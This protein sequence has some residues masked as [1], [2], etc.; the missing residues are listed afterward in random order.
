VRL[1]RGERAVA[2]DQPSPLVIESIGMGGE[3]VVNLGVDRRL[4][5]PSGSFANQ[6]IEW[7]AGVEVRAKREHLRVHRRVDWCRVGGCRS[8][9]HGVSPCPRRAVEE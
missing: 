1:P 9:S 7:T 3:E 4:Q 2:N 6:L 5:H 8:L